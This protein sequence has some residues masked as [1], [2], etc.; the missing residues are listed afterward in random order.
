MSARLPVLSRMEWRRLARKVSD[1]SSLNI[2]LSSEPTLADFGRKH[3]MDPDAVVTYALIGMAT[4]G[5][6]NIAD[7]IITRHKYFGINST[8]AAARF[9]PHDEAAHRIRSFG[10]VWRIH[11]LHA[12][13]ASQELSQ[14]DDATYRKNIHGILERLQAESPAGTSPGFRVNAFRKNHVAQEARTIARRAAQLV[15]LDEINIFEMELAGR[16]V[17]PERPP[18]KDNV[19][20]LRPRTD[21]APRS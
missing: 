13:A 9:Q 4:L 21:P 7:K 11:P 20:V 5:Y 10:Q 1:T 19:V 6:H 16:T 8:I 12:L 3:H 14:N 15:F 2:R 17:R 18:F